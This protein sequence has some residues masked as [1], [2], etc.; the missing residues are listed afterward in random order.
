ML[1]FLAT[2]GTE[3]CERIVVGRALCGMASELAPIG[4]QWPRPPLDYV[5]QEAALDGGRNPGDKWHG[6]AR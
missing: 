6:S 2:V 4:S 3:L 5:Q 1:A